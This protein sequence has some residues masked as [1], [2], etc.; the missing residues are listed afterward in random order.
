[1]ANINIMCKS[2]ARYGAD[3]EGSTNPVW[4]GCIYKKPVSGTFDHYKNRLIREGARVN[5]D[6]IRFNCIQ[7]L[8]NFPGIDPVEMA[9]SLQ[10]DGYNI[11]FDDSS[12]SV[13]ENAA[14]RARVNRAAK[15]AR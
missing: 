9:A 7:Y 3:C 15:E 14:N 6:G 10:N 2:C 4:T 13:K 8:C 11:L 5:P 12:I 1:M